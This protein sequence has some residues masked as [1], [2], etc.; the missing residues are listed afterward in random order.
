MAGEMLADVLLSMRDYR[1]SRT[2]AFASGS[3]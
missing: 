3:V 1:R 2:L